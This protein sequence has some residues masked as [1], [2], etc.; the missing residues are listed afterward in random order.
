MGKIIREKHHRLTPECYTGHQ[1]VVFTLCVQERK[2]VFTNNN[3][4][5]YFRNTL[6]E[7]AHRQQ[8]D[9]H[10]YLF[11]PDHL[12]L[13]IEGKS[14]DANILKMVN[15]FKQR[16]GYWLYQHRHEFHWQKDYY[17]HIIRN[18]EDL[19]KQIEYILQNPVRKGI[20]VDWKQFPHKGSTVYNFDEWS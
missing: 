20:V 15:G 9:I 18:S 11:M 13:I 1:I 17:D 12:H 14:D 4:V 5:E 6:L 19:R 2:S 3:I 10:M 8:C 16:T 7:E